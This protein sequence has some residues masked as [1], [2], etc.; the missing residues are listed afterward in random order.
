MGGEGPPNLR[1]LTNGGG[2]GGSAGRI[3]L[4]TRNTDPAIKAGAVIKPVH[5][6]DKTL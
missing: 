4:R 3:I 5:T 2:G 6:L 1:P